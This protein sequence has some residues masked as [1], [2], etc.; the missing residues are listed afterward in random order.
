MTE[1]F[2]EAAEADAGDMTFR[3]AEFGEPENAGS[4]P[5]QTVPGKTAEEFAP[6]DF[7][8]GFDGGEADTAPEPEPKD[9]FSAF[10]PADLDEPVFKPEPEVVKTEPAKRAE[11]ERSQGEAAFTAWEEAPKKQPEPAK[12]AAAE[13]SAPAAGAES[14]KTEKRAVTVPGE[15]FYKTLAEA[16]AKNNSVAIQNAVRAIFDTV[17]ICNI[18]GAAVDKFL[19]E[20]LTD[21]TRGGYIYNRLIPTSARVFA[22]VLRCICSSA[23]ENLAA[24][25]ETVLL[26]EDTYFVMPIQAALLTNPEAVQAIV[27]AVELVR[28]EK[29]REILIKRIKTRKNSDFVSAVDM[30]G[31]WNPYCARIFNKFG[32]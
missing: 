22:W 20:S 11:P 16:V 23:G 21:P 29:R 3:P 19:R 6:A 5:E 9:E 31:S 2:F 10:E 32:V 30:R 15:E 26:T 27:S 25:I 4:E 24:A 13:T 1:S 28:D 17:K 18:E 14:Y 12:T 7:D 8:S